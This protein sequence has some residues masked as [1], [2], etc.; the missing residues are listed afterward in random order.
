LNRL[1]GVISQKTEFF[2]TTAERTSKPTTQFK[3]TGIYKR[4]ILK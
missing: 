2:I 3:N 1:H 4:I